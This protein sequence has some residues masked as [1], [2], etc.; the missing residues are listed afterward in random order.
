MRRP[1]FESSTILLLAWSLVGLQAQAEEPPFDLP[2]NAAKRLKLLP[3]FT[4]G[5]ALLVRLAADQPAATDDELQRHV[6]RTVAFDC[7]WRTNLADPDDRSRLGDEE[8]GTTLECVDKK[9]KSIVPPPE[10]ENFFSEYLVKG[11]I[12]AI[13]RK[14]KTIRIE[15]DLENVVWLRSR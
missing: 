5:R 15:T 2:L 1:L 6:G 4:A 12:L 7:R 9:G 8:E 13:D 3:E 11:K 10:E 14:K